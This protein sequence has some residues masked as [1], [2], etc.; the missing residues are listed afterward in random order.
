MVVIILLDFC[1]DVLYISILQTEVL[2]TPFTFNT[3]FLG[4]PFTN[5]VDLS[6][7]PRFNQESG[8]GIGVSRFLLSNLSYIRIT[9]VRTVSSSKVP[10]RIGHGDPY[11][12]DLLKVN[13]NHLSLDLSCFLQT[14]YH[15]LTL[16]FNGKM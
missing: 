6:S 10:Y 4:F 1:N 12:W 8:G 2:L 13:E 14:V 5:P 16:F 7:P 9:N 11:T 3:V 15:I